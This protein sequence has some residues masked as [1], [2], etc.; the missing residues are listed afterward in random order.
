MKFVLALAATLASALATQYNLTVEGVDNIP[1]GV[2]SWHEGAGINYLFA[3]GDAPLTVDYNTSSEYVTQYVPNYTDVY[4]WKFSV[5]SDFLE[6][7]VLYPG[8]FSFDKGYLTING[9]DQWYACLNVNDPYQYSHT[10]NQ[11]AIMYT[12]SQG[13]CTPINIAAKEL[14]SSS[15]TETT[16]SSAAPAS[17]MEVQSSSAA[18]QTSTIPKVEEGSAGVMTGSTFAI[19]AALAVLL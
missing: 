7:G 3:L 4:E 17:S 10:A 15:S 1:T 11:Y 19:A 14:E 5:Y 8:N 18:L 13:Q 9:T 16:T 6:S 2:A 12:D